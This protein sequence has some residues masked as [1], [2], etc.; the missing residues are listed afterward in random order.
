MLRVGKMRRNQEEGTKKE[1]KKGFQEGG[2]CR[3]SKASGGPD[4]TRTYNKPLSLAEC[5]L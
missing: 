3:V 4:K 2:N 1:A 5:G